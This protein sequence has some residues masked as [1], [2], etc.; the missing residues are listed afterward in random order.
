MPISSSTANIKAERWC[1]RSCSVNK[2]SLIPKFQPVSAKTRKLMK[3]CPML[4]SILSAL[5]AL[6]VLKRYYV[7]IMLVFIKSN[8]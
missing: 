8:P 5:I 7:H 6:V 4:I 1:L 3:I 2:L